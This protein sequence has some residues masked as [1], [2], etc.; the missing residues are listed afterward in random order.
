MMIFQAMPEVNS[1]L[2][3]ARLLVKWIS[4]YTAREFVHKERTVRP[5][6]EQ[7]NEH[8][9]RKTLIARSVFTR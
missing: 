9:A 7:V 8:P 1:R 3:N 4:A 5:P 6:P 2:T